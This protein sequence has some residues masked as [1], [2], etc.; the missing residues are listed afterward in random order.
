MKPTNPQ[1]WERVK[2]EAKRKFKV[3]PSAYASGWLTKTYKQRGGGFRS[4][5]SSPLKRKSK[6]KSRRKSK[7]SKRSS[8]PLSRWY[9]EKWID[10]CKW[11]KRVSCGRKKGTNPRV[12]SPK[13]KSKTYP[14]C[15]PSKRVS[16]KTPTTVQELSPSRRKELCS[17]KR[18]SPS[19]RM[20]KAK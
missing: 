12:N 18:R 11:P 13:G 16:R 4:S 6:R 8:S 20:K 17:K 9:K 5:P 3:W 2:R 14:Y 15:R 1:L 7:S 19:K 10:A